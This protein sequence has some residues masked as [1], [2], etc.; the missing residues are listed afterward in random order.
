MHIVHLITGTVI[1]AL[2][3]AAAL[4]GRDIHRATRETRQRLEALEQAT[5]QHLNAPHHGPT[6]TEDSD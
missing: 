2:A 4:L 1:G 6:F 3:A 5:V